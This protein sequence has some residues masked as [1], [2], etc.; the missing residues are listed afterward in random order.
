M[1]ASN[2]AKIMSKSVD[3]N[4][5]NLEEWIFNLI[6]PS[7]NGIPV[8]ALNLWNHEWK[9]ARCVLTDVNSFANIVEKELVKCGKS[10][11]SD[12]H[13]KVQLEYKYLKKKYLKVKFFLS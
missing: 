4:L 12:E 11:Y 10:V 13:N 3:T 7:H 1:E 6:F 5:R 8:E 9:I 2:Q